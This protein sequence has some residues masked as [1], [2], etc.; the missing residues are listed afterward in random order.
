M[1]NSTILKSSIP[2]D[3]LQSVQVGTLNYSY[4]GV[5]CQKNPFDLA[6]YTKLIYELK[7]ATLIEIGTAAGGSALWF[8]DLFKTFKL[9]CQ[10]FSIDANQSS[11]LELENVKFLQGEAEKLERNFTQ[12]FLCRLP[13]P[14]LL[15]E[16]SA[17]L[18]ETTLAC[19]R[20]FDPY[21]GLGD[22]IVVE[23]GIVNDMVGQQ[24]DQY[25]NGPNRAIATFLEE[26]LGRYEIDRSY[27]D[28]YGENVTWNTNGY[29]KPVTGI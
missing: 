14:L 16:D 15:I 26:T 8:S 1:T 24:Y 10:I 9:D 20:F 11:S 4:R 6:L 21:L 29:I 18:Y 7:P 23:D 25:K 13:K 28:Y 3:L 12:D 2:P 17:H 19:L 22:F 27:C 5:P